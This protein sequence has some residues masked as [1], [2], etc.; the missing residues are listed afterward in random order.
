MDQTQIDT[1][2]GKP[3]AAFHHLIDGKAVP[4]SDGDTMNVVS[5]IDGQV[6]TTVAAGTA[7]DMN[8]AIASARAAFEDRRWAG[9]APAARK[10]VLLKW[11]DLIEA[12]AL[13][14][15]VLGVRDNGTEIGMALKAE[16]GSAAATI[17]YYAEALDKIYGEIAPTP[18]DILGMI[19]KEPV[20][21]VGA[22]IPWNFPLMI[23]AWKLGPALAMGNSVVLKPSETASLSLLRMAELA[24]EAGLPPGVLNVVT[25]EGR[26]V[27][28]TLGLSMDV[29]VLVFTGSGATGRRLMEYAAR[30]NMKRVY[31]ELGGKS[32]NIVFADA[33][34]LDEAAKVTA[35]GIFRNSGQVCVA[36][37]R[38]LV[39][40]PIHDEF[41]AAVTKA[42]DAMRVGDPLKVETQIGAVNSETQLQANLGF[43]ETAV[44]EGGQIVTGGARI[45]QDTG[46]YYMAPTIVTGVTQKATL[47]QKEVFGPVLGVTP[48][49]TEKEAVALANSTVY[50]LAGAAWTANLGRAHRMVK[51]VRTGVMH[52]NTYGGADGTVP[53][54]GVGQSGNG[55]D[56]SLHAIDKYVNLKTAWIKL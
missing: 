20:G 32:P 19:H 23:G 51:S 27:G 3:V 6:L 42:A 34:N 1:L 4:A 54:G 10:K 40:A 48:F 18:G 24:L 52:I 17:R 55:S 22:I 43:V 26:V 33:P 13:E 15:T 11:A 28:E 37:S 21:V 29:D 49:A 8:A 25:G 38:L 9:Q 12:N 35:A 5:P 53:L 39:E 44:S 46:G 56:K 31:L 7:E 16:P 45:L 14:L 30:S 50:G 36:G 2:R 41:V 47:A